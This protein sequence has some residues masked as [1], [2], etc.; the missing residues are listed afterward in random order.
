L[1]LP[2][3]ERISI[4]RSIPR[5]SRK[6]AIWTSISLLSPGQFG[7]GSADTPYRAAQSVLIDFQSGECGQRRIMMLPSTGRRAAGAAPNAAS[8]PTTVLFTASGILSRASRSGRELPGARRAA[9]GKHSGQSRPAD[10]TAA[11]DLEFTVPKSLATHALWEKR[12][13]EALFGGRNGQ[14]KIPAHQA[15][16]MFELVSAAFGT[17][18]LPRLPLDLGDADRIELRQILGLFRATVLFQ[19]GRDSRRAAN[20]SGRTNGLRGRCRYRA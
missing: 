16:L 19:I 3:L 18:Q 5:E 13:A 4:V 8:D 15:R 14:Q 10:S 6:A 20:A 11:D 12:D 9:T 17:G 2:V 1:V 7:Q